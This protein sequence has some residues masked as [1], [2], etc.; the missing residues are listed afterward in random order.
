VVVTV[1]SNHTGGNI[2]PSNGEEIAL[3][4][5][6]AVNAVHEHIGTGASKINDVNFYVTRVIEYQRTLA[7]RVRAHWG[8]KDGG[9]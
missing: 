1:D 9:Q 3:G 5:G 7:Q 4:N 6:D 2:G 8:E